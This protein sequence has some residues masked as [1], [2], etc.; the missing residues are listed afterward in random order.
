MPVVHLAT[1]G[2]PVTEINYTLWTSGHND[3]ALPSGSSRR[4]AGYYVESNWFYI[5]KSRVSLFK[6]AVSVYKSRR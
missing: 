3:P 4:G 6:S 2:G 1:V 5:I